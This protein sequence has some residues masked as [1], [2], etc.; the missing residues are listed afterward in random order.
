M[1]TNKTK[2]EST[3]HHD[4]HDGGADV[5]DSVKLGPEGDYVMKLAGGIGLG[6]LVVSIGLGAAAS[7]GFKQFFH[8][9]LVAFMWGLSIVLGALYWITLQHLVNS[10]WSVVIRRIAELLAQGLVL[11][12]VLALPILATVLKHNDVLYPWLNHELV[13]DNHVLHGKAGYLNVPFFLV[14]MVVYFGFWTLLARFY[15][16]RSLQQDS[17]GGDAFRTTMAKAAPPSMIAFALTLTFAAI[18]LIMTLD[19][20]WF[21][22][23]FGVYYFAGCV[24]AVHSTL[25]LS[26]FWLQSNGR[27][28]KS[29][30]SEHYHDIG[31]MMFAFTIFWAYVAFAQFMLI[32][33]ANVPEETQWYAKRFEGE[34]LAVSYLQ[35]VLHFVI[36]FF[37]LLSRHIKRNPKTLVMGA[38]WILLVHFLDLH[39][40][41]MPN[42]HRGGF[43]FHP[44]DIT[45]LLAVGCLLAAFILFRAKQVSLLATKD[46]RLKQSLAFEN[47]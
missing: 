11:M 18:D 15:L 7:D 30:T 24:L 46:P 34:W 5:T 39:W 31:K 45:T 6:F 37:F 8:S 21:S 40:L 47:I 35:I 42:F 44:L 20:M 19:P 12:G 22:T 43:S 17:T 23:I 14:R 16:K 33:Y 1:A 10:K 25:A 41:I 2:S 13:H 29:V 28:V 27:L 32:W 4:P 38:V 9:Y 3:G 36:P 26:L